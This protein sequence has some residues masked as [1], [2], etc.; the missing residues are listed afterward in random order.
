MEASGTSPVER[1]LAA[2]ER[3]L[4]PA[5]LALCGETATTQEEVLLDILARSASTEWGRAHGFEGIR[6]VAEYRERHPVTGWSDFE[7][8]AL[9]M[10]DG[11]EDL[12]FPGRPAIFLA[13]SATEGEQKLLPESAAGIRA[14]KA[15]SRLRLASILRTFPGL[16]R[17]GTVL[18]LSNRPETSFTAGGTPIGMAS[19][20]ALENFPEAIVGRIAFPL[21]VLGAGS[22]A[23]VD[24]LVMRLA[25]ERDVHVIVGN[26]AGRMVSLLEQAD[27]RRESL[28]REI[29]E[30]SIAPDVPLS[31]ELAAALPLSPNPDRAAFLAAGIAASGRLQP[32]DFWP[33][34]RLV[35]FWLSGSVGRYVRDLEPWLPP[36]VARMDCGYG[37]TEAKLNVPLGPDGSDGS[38]GPLALHAQL[39]EFLPVN[40][41]PPRLAHELEDGASYRLLLTTYSG[42]YR[43]DLRDVVRVE[44]F[45][46]GCPNIVFENKA[47]DVGNLAGER[48]TASQLLRFAGRVLAEAGVRAR[49]W[50]AFPDPDRHSYD[51][52]LEPGTGSL[53]LPADLPD[54]LDG[55]LREGSMPYGYYRGQGILRPLRVKVMAEGWTE[56]LYAEKQRQGVSINQV[57]LRV[58]V[59][60]LPHPGMVERVLDPA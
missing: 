3:E 38:A 46:A 45:T 20:S 16:A 33:H 27:R 34:L 23:S 12:L 8:L 56:R 51:F 24:Y 52:C 44:G 32:R 43:Y 37:A 31:P 42:L 1:L 53:E 17:E 55:A 15:T 48:L 22:H 7:P 11:E 60:A 9:R 29:A 35:T 13:T 36:G 10:Q 6:S 18:P 5:F 49:H 21:A 26:N 41:G 57:K 50:C 58:V 30:G 54:R 14:K 19:G 47:G 25:L 40:G 4:L 59:P 2:G 39:V 28:L